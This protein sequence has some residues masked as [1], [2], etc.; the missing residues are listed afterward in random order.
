MTRYRPPADPTLPTASR[1][2]RAAAWVAFALMD[3]QHWRFDVRGGEHL[4]RTGGAVIASNHTSFWDFFTVG[5]PPYHGLGRPVR[6]LAKDSLF[7]VP[8]FGGLMHAAEH[9]PVHRAAGASA[10]SSAVTALQRQE[11]VLVLPEQTISPALELLPFKSGAARMA[12]MAGVPLVPAAS[13]GSHRFHTVQRRPMPRWRLPVSIAYGEPLH[14]TPDDDPA[15]VTREL[16]RAVQELVDELMLTYPDG[17]PTGAWWVPARLGGG[18]PSPDEGDRYVERIR[19][20]N[21]GRARTG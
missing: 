13:W 20:S 18:A 19:R 2:Y 7:E 6:I 14:P 5:R 4:P 9:I 12:A 1:S 11:L 15:E 10:L 21:F 8:L 3:V 17:A 16:R